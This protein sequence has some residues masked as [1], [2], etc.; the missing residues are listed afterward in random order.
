MDAP[1]KARSRWLAE[2]VLP[3]EAMLR[4]RLRHLTRNSAVDID[5]VIQETYAILAKLESVE[6]IRNPRTYAVQV[7]K[8]VF[9]QSIRRKKVISIGSMSDLAA[10]EHFD[11]CPSP[12]QHASGRHELLRVKAA[13]ETMPLQVRRVFWL[14]RVEG[15]SQRETALRL[16]LAEHTVEKYVSRGIKFLLGQFERDGN[17]SLEAS[18]LKD[19]QCVGIDPFDGRSRAGS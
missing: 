6:G 19:P 2:H 16:G 4:A 12:E 7:A 10:L 18:S 15:L 13:I 14:R 8:S 5:D 1:Y 17:A 9:L 3:H 11:D